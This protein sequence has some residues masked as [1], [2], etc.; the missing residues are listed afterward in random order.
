MNNAGGYDAGRAYVL[1]CRV[2]ASNICGDVTGDEIVNLGDVVYLV[3]YLYKSG[4]PPVPDCVGDVNCDD[5]VNIG[6][7]VYLVSY[8]YKGGYS[9][10]PYCCMELIEGCQG[11]AGR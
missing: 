3:S 6:D 9:P 11:F 8:L 1:P 7:V 4:P 10:C 5:I 2:Y